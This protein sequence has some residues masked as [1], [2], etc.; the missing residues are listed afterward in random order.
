MNKQKFY[1]VDY[2]RAEA[3]Y[4]SKDKVLKEWNLCQPLYIF[5]AA[6]CFIYTVLFI[7]AEVRAYAFKDPTRELLFS[8][9]KDSEVKKEIE[10][11]NSNQERLLPG[12]H[13]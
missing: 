6:E 7:V 1:A 13:N 12:D 8:K 3:I 11:V 10:F 4:F 5:A 2:T 9:I